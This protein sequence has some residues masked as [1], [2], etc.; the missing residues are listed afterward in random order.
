MTR[1]DGVSRLVQAGLRDLGEAEQEMIDSSKG[2]IVG[3]FDVDIAVR[4]EKGEPFAK[5]ADSIVAKL[6]RDVYLSWDIDGLDPAL[7]PGT[8]TPV[9]GGFSWNEA[10]GLLRALQRAKKR[11]VGFDLCEVSPGDTEWNANVGARLLYK[12]IGYALLTQ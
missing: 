6:P 9:P 3:F 1:L 10:I 5:I 7:C 12:M 8:G 2:R 11:I 4:K